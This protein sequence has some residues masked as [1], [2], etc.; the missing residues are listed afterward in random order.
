MGMDKNWKRIC[1]NDKQGCVKMADLGGHIAFYI[2]QT[3]FSAI[4]TIKLVTGCRECLMARSVV[5]ISAT[6][7]RKQ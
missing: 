6:L 7:D 5:L 4:I 2:F 3:S 1:H